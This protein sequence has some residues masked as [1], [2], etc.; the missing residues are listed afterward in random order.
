MPASWWRLCSSWCRR[1]CGAK[2]RPG[3]V[4]GD[5]RKGTVVTAVTAEP[6][7]VEEIIE[8]EQEEQAPVGMWARFAA[9]VKRHRVLLAAGIIAL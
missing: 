9:F 4:P 7:V 1:A 2:R 3:A 6:V 8:A 5:V